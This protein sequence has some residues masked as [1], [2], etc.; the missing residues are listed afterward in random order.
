[1]NVIKRAFCIIFVLVIAAA[2][3]LAL[4]AWGNSALAYW[5]GTAAVGAGVEGECPLQVEKEV[6]TFDIDAFPSNEDYPDEKTAS[7]ALAAY[8]E[9]AK[10]TA[11]YTFYN[12][13]TYDVTATLA[14]PFGATPYY[15]DQADPAD[16][17][18]GAAVDGVPVSTRLRHTLYTYNN[19]V[20]LKKLVDGYRD[21]SFFKFDLPVTRYYYEYRT[22]GNDDG[23]Y[24]QMT[25]KYGKDIRFS[26]DWGTYEDTGDG[27]I[28]RFR[29]T[30]DR[31][32]YEIVFFGGEPESVSI[33]LF[34][35]I[36]QKTPVR[37]ESHRLDRKTKTCTF[38]ELVFEE[39]DSAYGVSE[40]DWYNAFLD[41]L[42]Q[43]EERYWMQNNEG[44]PHSYRIHHLERELMQW[45]EY[46][47]T[48]PAGEKVVNTVT[49]PLFPDID[50]GYEPPVYNYTYLLSPARTWAKFGALEVMINTPFYLIESG[51]GDFEA[52]EGGFKRS[53]DGLPEGELSFKLSSDPSP[54][55]DRTFLWTLLIVIGYLLSITLIVI[56]VTAIVTVLVVK[57]QQKKKQEN[58]PA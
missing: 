51:V 37:D 58:T 14:F 5:S 46:D 33:E 1:M 21:D 34:A 11:E 42:L 6:L 35:D 45:Y 26:C 22:D 54:K 40:S 23:V 29:M 43:Y 44:R 39:N 7:G 49:A 4:A 20:D 56:G 47:M 32:P 19:E 27:A 38:R 30:S 41:R 57:K 3:M 16:D 24:V 50:E 2:P 25:V 10:V 8:M 48:V 12:P 15:Y 36:D 52:V 18:W 55:E 17:A 9:N 53:F 31:Y 13:A 28:L